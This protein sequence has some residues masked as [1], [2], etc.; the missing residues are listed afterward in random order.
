V[1]LNKI[2]KLKDFVHVLIFLIEDFTSTIGKP[3]C[4]DTTRPPLTPQEIEFNAQTYYEQASLVLDPDKTEVRYNSKWCD[5]LGTRGLIQLAS[6]YTVARMLE[7]DDFTKRYQKHLPIA[8]HEFIYPLLQGYDSV[9]LKADL[10]L[11]GTDQK[12]NLLVCRELQ[13]E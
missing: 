12:F 10:E 2:R 5:E 1:V 3:S 13:K 4:R 6:R 11:G 7:R 9:Q 8:I